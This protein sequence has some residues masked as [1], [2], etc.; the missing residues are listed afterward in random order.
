MGATM[1][2]A[3]I[4][5]PGDFGVVAMA[6]AFTGFVGL[7]ADLGLSMATVQKPQITHSQVSALFW[8]NVAVSAM[9]GGAAAGLAPFVAWFYGREELLN[10]TIVIG[11][12]FILSGLGAQHIAL[13]RRQ[14]RFSALAVIDIA[15]VICGS[16]VAIIVGVA[17][18]G[19]WALVA[20]VVAQALARTIMGFSLSR[21]RPGRPGDMAEVRS[22]LGFGANLTG[23]SLLNYSIRNADNMIL[24]YIGGAAQLGLYTKAYGLLTMPLSQ[25]LSPISAVTVPALCRLVDNP[26]EFR[27]LFLR[28]AHLV[29]LLV[30]LCTSWAFAVAPELVRIVLGPGWEQTIVIFRILAIGTIVS[31]TNIAGA[32]VATP[33][34]RTDRQLRLAA[35]AAPVYIAAFAVGSR[36]GAEGVAAAFTATCCLLRIPTFHYLLKDSPIRP[37]DIGKLMIRPVSLAMVACG[38][39]L[40]AEIPLSLSTP[41]SLL[42]KSG[43]FVAIVML[44]HL[45]GILPLPVRAVVQRCFAPLLRKAGR[46]CT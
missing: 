16:A 38:L 46:G 10:I 6:S 36:W 26:T 32:W 22:L 3:R 12:T 11:A 34:G 40:G 37:S 23:A 24:G 31:S 30:V 14:M 13:L 19:Y 27:S 4:L 39:A 8:V 28:S 33:M 7:F 45:T 21:W 43:V 44:G 25:F 2:L 42:L 9:L 17:G 35:V 18:G 1:I 20:L 15:T 41:Y 5:I 29:I